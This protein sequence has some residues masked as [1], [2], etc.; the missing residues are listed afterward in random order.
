MRVRV[1]LGFNGHQFTPEQNWE[2]LRT[3]GVESL[4]PKWQRHPF[5]GF[6][7]DEGD[8]R[9]QV[10]IEALQRRGQSFT[11]TR[12]AEYSNNDLSVA[13]VLV[14]DIDRAPKGDPQR[15]TKYDN[16]TGCSH[17]GTGARQI[18]PLRIVHRD[19]PKESLVCQTLT[20]EILFRQA[21]LERL[22]A[23][24]EMRS[25]LREM[26]DVRTGADLDWRQLLPRVVLPKLSSE[27]KG[28]VRHKPCAVCDRD[29][30][31]GTNAVPF[32]PA[33][34]T[35][36]FESSTAWP[37]NINQL[38][39]D[40]TCTHEHFGNSS[41]DRQQDPGHVVRFAQPQIVISNRM[42]RVLV[43]SRVRGI[44]YTPIKIIG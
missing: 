40:I 24:V 28:L 25:D 5:Y 11:L 38:P 16:S 10:A 7:I 35:S 4:A 39:P 19:L 43:E 18:G 14:L 6:Q 42:M 31:F 17:C 12:T 23:V 15:Y 41:L 20:G 29:G 27:T 22:E 37:R 33:L 36:D 3:A 44:R 2:L 30:Y 26:Q 9:L 32:E 1:Y 13:P 21:L 34:R 8:P